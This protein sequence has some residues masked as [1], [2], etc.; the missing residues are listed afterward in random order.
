MR[1]SLQD[2]YNQIASQDAELEKQAS[3]LIKQ[4]E[5]EDAAGRITA[6]GF[7]D[8]LSKLAAHHAATQAK[9]AGYDA[10]ASSFDTGPKGGAF[11]PGGAETIKSKPGYDLGNAGKSG[12]G[13]KPAGGS[14]TAAVPKP[15][16]VSMPAANMSQSPNR[17]GQ[18]R[19]SVA[20]S[21]YMG[22]GMAPAKGPVAAGAM[23]PPG[24]G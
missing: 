22:K 5:E 3:E 19:A 16:N 21:P 10:G 8:E 7:A 13:F 9:L 6:R 23:K 24:Q 11:K 15:G 20:G 17:P 12:Q 1:N 14:R 4:A 18:N 2:V